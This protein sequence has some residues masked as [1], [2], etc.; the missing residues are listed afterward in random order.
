MSGP[1]NRCC[2]KQYLVRDPHV[3]YGQPQLWQDNW[4]FLV[5]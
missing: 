5:D 2:T 1:P 4:Y 3:A